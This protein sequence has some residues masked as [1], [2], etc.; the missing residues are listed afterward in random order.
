VVVRRRA[1]TLADVVTV[2]AVEPDGLLVTTAGAYVRLLGLGRVLQPRAGGRAHRELL[3]E[4]LG[5]LAA[6]MPA[7][8][9]LQV[10]VSA[11]PLDPERALARDWREIRAASARACAA[12]E[13]MRRLGY[14]LEQTVRASA[15]VVGAGAL[16]WSVAMR[17]TPGR[18]SRSLAD[19]ARGLPLPV[20]RGACRVIGRDAH[21]LAAQESLQLVETVRGDLLAAGC[22]AD[23]LAGPQ[24]L[25]ALARAIDPARRAG[26]QEFARLPQVLDTSEPGLALAHRDEL[27]RALGGG[28]RLRAGR[29]VLERATTDDGPREVE[30]VLHLS[31]PP[32]QTS[33]WWLLALLEV[34]PPW[35]L[36][37]HVTATD[38]IRQRRRFARR[39][40]RLWAD[41]RRRERDGKLITEDAYEQE[42]EAAEIAAELRHG[43]AG[44]LYDVGVYLALRRPAEQAA[45]LAQ[46]A[47]RLAREFEHETDARLYGGRFLVEDSWASTLPLATDVLGASRRFAQRNI[48]DCL[49]LLSM[50]AS[51]RGGVPLGYAV[52]G[53]TLERVDLFDSRYRTHVALVTGASGSG[54][55]VAV[56]A[57]LARNIARGARG[58]IIDRSSSE[59]EGGST[60]HA[61][62]YEQL[63]QLVPGAR[64]LHLGARQRD[65]VL[66]PWDVPDPNVVPAGKVEF[67]LALQTLL[68]GDPTPAG[69]ALAGL[70]RTLLTRAIQAVYARSARTGERARERLLFEEL[71]RLAREQAAD[72][73]DGDATVASELRRLAERLHPY[74]DDGPVAW[75]T[76]HE[77]TLEPGARLV[78]FDLAGLP[79]ALAGPV[80]LTLVDFIDRDVAHRRA[81]HVAG[82]SLETGPWAGRAFVAIDEAW[83]Q[84]LTAEAGSWLNEWARRTRHIACALLVITQHLEDFANP[85]GRALLRNSVLRLLFHTAFDELDG[86][87]DALGYHDEDLEAIGALETRK[88]EYSSCLLDSEA[89]GRASVRIYLSDLEYWACSADPDRDQPL[90]ALALAEAGG[91]TWAAMRR[92]VDPAWHHARAAE[93]LDDPDDAVDPEDER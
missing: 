79:D 25:A 51:S 87:R 71:R 18:A 22:E 11:E 80:I 61:G 20:G 90:R 76:D 14:G 55:T 58:Y 21:E 66:C 63:A 15:P 54:K 45:E 35:R 49:P 69:P 75:L 91:D 89:H 24:A 23:A 67:L 43:A 93:L 78:V 34:P 62:H 81:H 17:W 52:P 86:V 56:N 65:A 42:D 3:R 40:R 13:A 36:A 32:G 48:A 26:P 64:V 39:H 72:R 92:L 30:A 60:R 38:R 7:G 33:L 47:A 73:A 27:V 16:E 74:I 68:I 37:V 53:G 10:V 84:L 59:D 8:H 44:G 19:A 5:T 83:K 85:Q 82:H 28:V 12:S 88:G 31:A 77:T 6:A 70:E 4:R 1:R 50:S 29:D 41:L 2:A 9:G 46:F 57:L